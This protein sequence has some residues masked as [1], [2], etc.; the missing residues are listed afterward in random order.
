MHTCIKLC[1]ITL[2][3]IKIEGINH[4]ANLW[5]YT[6]QGLFAAAFEQLDL[7]AQRGCLVDLKVKSYNMYTKSLGQGKNISSSVHW[8]PRTSL[9]TTSSRL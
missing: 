5:F 4:S 7:N 8:V 9:V 1:F 6:V 3:G 2:L